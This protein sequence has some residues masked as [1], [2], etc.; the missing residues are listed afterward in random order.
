MDT[1]TRKAALQRLRRKIEVMYLDMK[2]QHN[3]RYHDLA[4]MLR[5]IEILEQEDERLIG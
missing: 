4:E 1:E 3:T 5:L 2:A